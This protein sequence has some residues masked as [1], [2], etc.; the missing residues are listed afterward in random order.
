MGRKKLFNVEE[1][2]AALERWFL[3][4]GHAPTI[5]EFTDYLGVGS[6]RTA[7]RYLKELE[8]EGL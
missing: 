2:Y 7:L 1:A 8:K 6:T 5:Q 3:E 4:R